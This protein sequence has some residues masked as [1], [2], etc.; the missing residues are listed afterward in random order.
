MI[1]GKISTVDMLKPAGNF[2]ETNLLM[3]REKREKR[4]SKLQERFAKKQVR[5]NLLKGRTDKASM[6]Y[7]SKL[8][9][10]VVKLKKRLQKKFKQLLKTIQK[11]ERNKSGILELVKKE[12][13]HE[14]KIKEAGIPI[15]VS[16]AEQDAV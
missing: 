11:A 16:S 15:P 2:D 7:K 9:V 8:R 5:L 4:F 12:A 3:R 13:K 10:Q 6:V 14:L 1:D